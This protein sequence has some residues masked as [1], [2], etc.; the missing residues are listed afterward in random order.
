MLLLCAVS[1]APTVAVVYLSMCLLFDII[2][3]SYPQ[4]YI[5]FFCM[6]VGGIEEWKKG[7]RRKYGKLLRMKEGFEPR[8]T[9]AG[10]LIGFLDILV[11]FSRTKLTSCPLFPRFVLI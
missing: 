5:S 6:E 3:I 2:I 9:V 4:F 11:N 8:A 7:N 10:V 1:V